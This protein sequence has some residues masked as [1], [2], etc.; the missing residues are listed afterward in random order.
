M[1]KL[2]ILFVVEPITF[3]NIVILLNELLLLV[4][5]MI[6]N[7]DSLKT[8]YP[9]ISSENLENCLIDTWFIEDKLGICEFDFS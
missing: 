9:G 1:S 7:L 5:P 6:V 4:L 8:G 2:A 3:V